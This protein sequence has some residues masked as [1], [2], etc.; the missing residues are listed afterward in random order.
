MNELKKNLP[1]IAL[2]IA[3]A[4]VAY[5]GVGSTGFLNVEVWALFIGLILGNIKALPGRF[6]SGMK[7]SGKKILNTAVALMGLQFAFN[8]IPIQFT[9]LLVLVF[10]IVASS[11]I[12]FYLARRIGILPSCGL[13][14][15]IGN[16]ICGAS[17]IAAVSPFV[18][19]EDHETG[20]A[21]GVVNV[22][23]S[24]AMVTMPLLVV[25][26]SFDDFEASFLIGGTLQAV[27][28]AVG[29]G[30]AVNET[31]G[32]WATLI[33]MTRVSLLI[34]VVLFLAIRK[35]RN[36]GGGTKAIRK[37]FPNFLIIF[38]LLLTI[39]NLVELQSDFLNTV[40]TIDKALLTVA[41]AG[42]GFQINFSDIRNQGAR[43]LSLGVMIYTIQ[44]LVVIAVIY[45][46]L[47]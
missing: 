11:M 4:G 42:L 37:A 29:A 33:K 47:L 23:G 46:G 36:T 20:V 27:G 3:I 30:Y 34:P 45:S 13:M 26:L 1:G 10:L 32:E 35:G 43:A 38:L 28:Q 18:Q 8:Q 17:A 5:L 15:G 25:A 6:N 16:S 14:I 21:V 40:K 2:A 12:G 7:F 22:L 41:M 44:V 31:V 24:I 9:S 19:Q 39:T